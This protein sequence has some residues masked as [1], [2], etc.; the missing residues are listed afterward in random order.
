MAIRQA[1]TFTAL[2]VS[3]GVSTTWSTDMSEQIAATNIIQS[4]PLVVL[5]AVQPS[6]GTIAATISDK[7]VTYTGITPG[8][9]GS[10]FEL[11]LQ[12]AF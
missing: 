10:T 6:I 5:L 2:V 9:I 7:V 8:S 3:D 12:L 1:I 11:V 4:G